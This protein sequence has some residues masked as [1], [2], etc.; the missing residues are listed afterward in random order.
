MTEFGFHMDDVYQGFNL[1]P[2]LK[3]ME[4]LMRDSHIQIGDNPLLKMHFLDSGLKTDADSGKVK[5]IK[6]DP[7]GHIDG[8]AALSD[9]MCV[10]QKWYGE[11]GEQLENK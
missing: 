5:L 1:S 9:A 11:I 6:V 3:E 2:V 10:R 8:M 4:G 7:R